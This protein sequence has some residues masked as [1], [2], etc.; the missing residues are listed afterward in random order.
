MQKS[1]FIQTDIDKGCLHAGQHAAHYAFVDITYQAAA[2]SA[3][4]KDFLQHPVLDYRDPGFLWRHI[5]Q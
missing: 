2:A 1:G 5:S 4:D 3:L